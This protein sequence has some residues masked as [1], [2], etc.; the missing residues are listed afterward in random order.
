MEAT[1][2]LKRF[3]LVKTNCRRCG[4]EVFTGNRSLYGA[5]RLKAEL[6]GICSGCITAEEEAR[7]LSGQVEAILKVVANA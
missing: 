4:C 6:G 7:I 3:A 2:A 1:M 5:D